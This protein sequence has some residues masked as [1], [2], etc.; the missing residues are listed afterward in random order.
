MHY[1][2]IKKFDIANG[3]GVRIS[4]FVSGCRNHCPNCFNPSTWNFDYG[5]EFTKDIE[6]EILNT[7]KSSYIRGLS[8]LGGEPMEPENQKGLLP[9]LKRVKETLP[10]KDIWV[11]TG[12]KLDDEIFGQS[13]AAT[14]V[15]KEL[16]KYVDVMVDGR[17]IEE[18]KNIS[19][20]F[21]GSENQR[22]I[23][24][25]KTL[26]A[27]RIVLWEEPNEHQNQKA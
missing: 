21:R 19:L 3:L 23:D 18:Q 6:D 15:A 7:L 2:E 4:L 22:I 9:F 10:E 20:R 17:Y 1:A 27:D 16:L 12:F 25:Q 26:A 8:V 5:K 13:R 11:Y 24:V 14:P